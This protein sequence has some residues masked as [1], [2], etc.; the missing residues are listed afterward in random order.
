MDRKVIRFR[1]SRRLLRYLLGYSFCRTRY[2]HH[3]ACCDSASAGLCG[4][5]YE[6][7]FSPSLVRDSFDENPCSRNGEE[8]KSFKGVSGTLVFEMLISAPYKLDRQLCRSRRVACHMPAARFCGF[9][10]AKICRIRASR[11]SLE[12]P[13]NQGNQSPSGPN[14]S[15]KRMIP[16]L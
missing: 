13:S 4:T 16:K 15:N 3:W 6:V 9:T 1:A 8:P 2:V 10:M 11:R 14:P 5:T 12:R 7:M